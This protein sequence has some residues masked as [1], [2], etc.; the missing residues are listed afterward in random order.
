[1]LYYLNRSNKYQAPLQISISNTTIKDK[2]MHNYYRLLSVAFILCMLTGCFKH[3]LFNK[4]VS[5]YQIGVSYYQ[6]GS[7]Q[8][9]SFIPPEKWKL[10]KNNIWMGTLHTF[11]VQA[12]LSGQTD[13]IVYEQE[14]FYP[15]YDYFE[16]Q[17]KPGKQRF[18]SSGLIILIHGSIN[19]PGK[20][21]FAQKYQGN[22]QF[23]QLS[24]DHFTLTDFLVNKMSIGQEIID[25][26][27][28]R[29]PVIHLFVTPKRSSKIDTIHSQPQTSIPKMSAPKI[30]IPKQ[31]Q[32]SLILEEPIPPEPNIAQNKPLYLL[33]IQSTF[34]HAR[35]AGAISHTEWKGYGD[36]FEAKLFTLKVSVLT[37]D[38]RIQN[39]F[40]QKGFAYKPSPINDSYIADLNHVEANTVPLVVRV[41]GF[42]K[43]PPSLK[44][45][46]KLQGQSTFFELKKDSFI[47][48]NRGAKKLEIAQKTQI[49]GK[50]CPLVNLYYEQHVIQQQKPHVD[51][52]VTITT[53]I[54]DYNQVS[55]S[56]KD[57]AYLEYINNNVIIATSSINQQEIA[58]TFSSDKI[59]TIVQLSTRQKKIQ[60][61]KIDHQRYMLSL[62]PFTK[63]IIVMN[64]IGHPISQASV[65][66]YVNRK[67]TIQLQNERSNSFLNRF[68]HL[69]SNPKESYITE[70]ITLYSGK[71][72]HNG[73][74]LFVDPGYPLQHMRVDIAK[75]GYQVKEN[76][77]IA[78]PLQIRLEPRAK[79][80]KT[81]RLHYAACMDESE[82]IHQSGGVL[83]IYKEGQL[84]ASLP[85]EDI[86][87]LPFVKDPVFQFKHPDYLYHDITMDSSGH[88]INIIPKARIQRPQGQLQVLII[89]DVT[90]DDPRGVAFLKISE[91]LIRYL[92]GIQWDTL[93]EEQK[94]RIK[95]AS[96][97][98][99][100]LNYFTQTGE[101]DHNILMI[102]ADCSVTEQL[103][104]AFAQFDSHVQGEKKVI[105]IISSRRA[106]V[107]VDD[108]IVNRINTDRLIDNQTIFSGL[109]VGKYGGKGFQKL[110]N[111]T[112]G[113]FSYCKTS[114]D[115]YK[116]LND[117]VGS[118]SNESQVISCSNDP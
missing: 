98:Q 30:N 83:E 107:V 66:I 41:Y 42:Q 47:I 80:L 70:K 50:Y 102:Q 4:F 2:S 34:D 33:G 36:Y 60:A 104:K 69:F 111:V 71:T 29:F 63:H 53:T 13:S 77:P 45:F 79:M 26:S 59:P 1:M 78:F 100:Y 65:H 76:I 54:E 6:I 16:L 87:L 3:P 38:R 56:I 72:N 52:E 49:K 48:D 85:P 108:N 61:Q 51:K 23:I 112:S 114:D 11:Q 40:K 37:H 24:A 25:S 94:Y 46:Q 32:E 44:F 31:N 22:I 86:M 12:T 106:S 18:Y 55:S 117:I 21:T 15:A 73:I 116:K 67:R 91:A 43:Q 103:E 39:V 101:I 62:K 118:L 14:G 5:P 74:A 20:L 96:A 82:N 19:N 10:K 109:V 92:N 84:F 58:Y 89:M 57:L 105:Y 90:D 35:I 81:I 99:D 115:I 97:Y 93:P 68:Y 110:S 95:V 7:Y 27:G 113:H 8:V 75:S 17:I 88:Q 64:H 9:E 28:T